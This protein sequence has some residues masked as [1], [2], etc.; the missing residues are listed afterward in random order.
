MLKK[1]MLFKPG[2]IAAGALILTLLFSACRK[3]SDNTPGDNTQYAGLLSFN[4][5]PDKTSIAFAVGGAAITTAPLSYP[6]YT[7][8]Y[9]PI[10]PGSRKVEAFNYAGTDSAFASATNSF[11]ANKFYS[12]YAVGFNNHYSTVISPDNIDSSIIGS[13]KAYVRYINAITDSSNKN[14]SIEKSGANVFDSTVSFSAITPFKNVDAGNVTVTVNNGSNVN[15]NRT[16]AVEA[17]KVYTI[18]LI[19]VPGSSDIDKQVKI[20]Y[21]V[22]GSI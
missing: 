21:V 19:G 17:G 12:V 14:V 11:V 15:V 10:I 2:L 4:L 6:N 5:I 16:F 1:R 8:A 9:Q 22:N 18:L 20:V 13:G 3:N 7:G